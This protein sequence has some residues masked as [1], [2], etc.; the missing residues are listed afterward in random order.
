MN[1]FFFKIWILFTDNIN[2]QK[3]SICFEDYS[4]QE[5][6][7]ICPK[8]ELQRRIRSEE[9]GFVFLK[10]SGIQLLLMNRKFIG[11]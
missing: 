6:K 2:I 7:R 1:F 3:K 4:V 8:R 10:T 9:G 11:N 5:K